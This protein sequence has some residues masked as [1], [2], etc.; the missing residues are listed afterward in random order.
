MN[1]QVTRPV[2]RSRGPWS[3]TARSR[4]ALLDAAARDVSVVVGYH[5]WA[6]VMVDRHDGAYHAAPLG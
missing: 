2:N 3:R 4:R 5:L 6:P 1:S